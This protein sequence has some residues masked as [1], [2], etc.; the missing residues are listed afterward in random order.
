LFV[1]NILSL[2]CSIYIIWGKFNNILL[3]IK[4]QS[5]QQDK[6]K[7]IQNGIISIKNKVSILWFRV[8][9]KRLRNNVCE[10]VQHLACIPSENRTCL[11]AMNTCNKFSM[12]IHFDY[13]RH[14]HKIS[15]DIHRWTDIEYKGNIGDK[16]CTQH[17]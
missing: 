16:M 8:S 4:Y 2:L 14:L 1:S 12:K 13:S 9:I 7:R 5:S 11:L 10:H 15:H 17:T 6:I 3:L